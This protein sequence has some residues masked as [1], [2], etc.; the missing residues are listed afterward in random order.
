[1]G[2]PLDCLVNY[3]S[4]N[5]DGAGMPSRYFVYH[6]VGGP[7]AT[8][9]AGVAVV[10]T[11]AVYAGGQRCESCQDFHVVRDGGPAAAIDKALRYLD[12]FHADDRL[13]KVRSAI[14]GG[15]PVDGAPLLPADPDAEPPAR[16][17]VEELLARLEAGQPVTVLD[18]RNDE[19]WGRSG[20]KVRGAVRVDRDRLPAEPL[21]KDRLTVAYCTCPNDAGAVLVAQELQE[22]GFQQAYALRG[23]LDAWRAAGGPVEP[24]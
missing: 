17:S 8:A 24:R 7:G 2:Q 15:G 11:L 20:V 18:A 3:F 14:R 13:R 10:H 4:H 6:V 21:P 19:E 1:M 5:E 22:H 23:G 12:A 16:M 9:G